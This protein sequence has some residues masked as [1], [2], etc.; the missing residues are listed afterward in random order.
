LEIVD[1]KAG[2]LSNQNMKITVDLPERSVREICRFAGE[3]K[4]GP[5]IRKMVLEA[6]MLRKRRE[7]LGK[8]T[9][10]KLSVDFPDWRELRKDCGAKT[11]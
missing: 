6:A 1:K 5:A 8:V 9:S 11:W 10:G 3:K 2:F 4:K 7:L